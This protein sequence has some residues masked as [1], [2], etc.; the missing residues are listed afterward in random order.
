MSKGEINWD[1]D[2]RGSMSVAINDR[3]GDFMEDWFLSMMSTLVI[4][5]GPQD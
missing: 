2:D 5:F 4:G 1:H 3:G